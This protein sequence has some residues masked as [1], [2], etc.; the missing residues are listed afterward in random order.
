MGILLRVIDGPMTGK[1]FKFDGPDI[2]LFGRDKECHCCLPNDSFISRH[3]FIL[4][5]N[6]PECILKDLGSLNGTYVNEVK[7]GGRNSTDPLEIEE[8]QKRAREVELKNKDIIN[9]GKTRIEVIVEKELL[10]SVNC[11]KCNADIAADQKDYYIYIG[12]TYLCK[13]CRESQSETKNENYTNLIT[14]MEECSSKSK[15]NDNLLD[16]MLLMLYG[17][18]APGKK[19]LP[20]IPGYDFIKELGKGGFGKVYLVKRERDKKEL[21]MK[22]MLAKKKEVR[23]KDIALFRQEMSNCMKLCHGNIVEFEEQDYINGMFYFTMEYC[24]GGSVGSLLRK[25]KGIVSV[26][27]AVRYILQVLEGL[28][29]IH[30]NN[31]V[32]RDLKPDN[33]LLDKQLKVAKIADLGL[34]RNFRDSGLGGF[35]VPINFAGTPHYMPKEQVTDFKNVTPASDVFSIGA[36]FYKMITGWHVY[37]FEGIK[38]PIMAILRERIV[39]VR[40]R[41]WM[42]PKSIADVID[43]AISPNLKDRYKNAEEMKKALE[44]AI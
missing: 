21:A 14:Q 33:I 1:E 11:V 18:A 2:F 39:P 7:H 6:P 3:Q 13:N 12:G 35:S 34:A 8:A 20:Q 9:V 44:D 10:K 17:Q 41:K 19:R 43:V 24:G 36:T 4:E 40:R 28:S 15:S 27:E 29:F 32:H 5:V 16:E 31:Y 37:D 26:E 38:D 23:E 42:L 22:L 25:N 30:N